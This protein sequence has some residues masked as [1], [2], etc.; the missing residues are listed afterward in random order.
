MQW[1]V[2]TTIGVSVGIVTLIQCLGPALAS[3]LIVYFRELRW[4]F[5]FNHYF[6]LLFWIV[7]GPM[8]VFSESLCALAFPKEYD[9]MHFPKNDT[10]KA[11]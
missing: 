2:V 10:G 7:A 6:I 3:A 11:G 5:F 1:D 9:R 8:I 4:F